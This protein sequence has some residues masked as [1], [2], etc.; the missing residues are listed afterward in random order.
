MSTD[1]KRDASQANGRLSRGPVTATGKARS[2]RN[3]VRHGLTAERYT[4]VGESEDEFRS[5][6][7]H[8][9]RDIGPS[10]GLEEALAERIVGALWRLRRAVRV[11]N[12][13]I[14][15]AGVRGT[16]VRVARMFH[17]ARDGG[18][19]GR[20]FEAASPETLERVARYEVRL[21]RALARALAELEQL[22]K[23][24]AERGP[25]EPESTDD[26]VDFLDAGFVSQDADGAVAAEPSLADLVPSFQK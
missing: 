4:V 14:G 8:I 13:V 2:A 7:A 12:D 17:S 18:E 19:L 9:W 11:E 16:I 3:A 25:E 20:A 5:F 22:R 1:A 10:G 23:A 24:R 26:E 21:E 6:R 15:R